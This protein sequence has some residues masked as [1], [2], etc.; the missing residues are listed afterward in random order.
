VRQETAAGA[1]DLNGPA[2]GDRHVRRQEPRMT[3][4]PAGKVG[5]MAF[6][7]GTS[8]VGRSSIFRSFAVVS[9]RLEVVLAFPR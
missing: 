7:T 4:S 6:T 5:T 1:S 9:R 2:N 3:M 8:K